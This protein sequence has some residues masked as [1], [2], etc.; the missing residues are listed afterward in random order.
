M[1]FTLYIVMSEVAAAGIMI[2]GVRDGRLPPEGGRAADTESS[3]RRPG[4][5]GIGPFSVTS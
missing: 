3:S 4:V 2:M 1:S 5:P